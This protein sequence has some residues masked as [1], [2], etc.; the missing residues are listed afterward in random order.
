MVA[1]PLPVTILDDLISVSCGNDHRKRK[2][3]HPR[4]WPEAER[5][6]FSTIH[7]HGGKKKPRLLTLCDNTVVLPSST[8]LQWTILSGWCEYTGSLWVNC[9][10][11]QWSS[12]L[13]GFTSETSWPGKGFHGPQSHILVTMIL[14]RDLTTLVQQHLCFSIWAWTTWKNILVNLWH[15]NGSADLGSH[16]HAKEW[17]LGHSIDSQHHKNLWD[18]QRLHSVFHR[19][20]QSW[21]RSAWRV[22]MTCSQRMWLPYFNNPDQRSEGVGVRKD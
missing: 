13:Q 2:W 1:F 9:K 18:W 16:W 15:E 5:P 21:I 12:W 17:I 4:W 20:K 3:G 8:A 14:L 11:T 10:N 6:P 22:A 7:H 19:L